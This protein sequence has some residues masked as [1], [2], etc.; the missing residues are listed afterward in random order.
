MNFKAYTVKHVQKVSFKKRLR[1][2]LS[3]P[4]PSLECDVLF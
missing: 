3:T 4:T 2:T 1:E